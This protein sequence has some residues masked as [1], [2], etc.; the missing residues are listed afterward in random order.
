MAVAP[1]FN[2]HA[3]WSTSSLIVD[4]R[5]QGEIRQGVTLE[6]FG[7]G[8]SPGP[9]SPEMKKR[10]QGNGDEIPWTTLTEYLTYLEKRGVAPNVASFIRRGHNSRVCGWARG[11]KGHARAVGANEG[12]GS[13]ARWKTARWV[14]ARH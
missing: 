4:P 2:Q 8:S 6:I 13:S 3:S 1:G 5:S 14:S 7:E 9:L 11:Q 12:A 10:E